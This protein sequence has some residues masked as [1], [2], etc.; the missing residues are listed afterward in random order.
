MKEDLLNPKSEGGL[1]IMSV[2]EW[3]R[4]EMKSGRRGEA[5]ETWERRG[6]RE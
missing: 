3:M 6:R 2:S 5:K 1:L 4:E